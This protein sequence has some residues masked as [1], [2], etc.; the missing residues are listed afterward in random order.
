M[1]SSCQACSICYQPKESFAQRLRSSDKEK[2]CFEKYVSV[3]ET[4]L[5]TSD[6]TFHLIAKPKIKALYGGKKYLIT[7]CQWD[8]R[9]SLWIKVWR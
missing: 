1:P 7:C 2:Q 6:E 8:T 9:N 5:V 3:N 4:Y